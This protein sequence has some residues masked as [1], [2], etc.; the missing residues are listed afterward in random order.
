MK[1]HKLTLILFTICFLQI[2]FCQA[3]DI[4]RTYHWYFGVKAGIDFSNGYAQPDTTGKIAVFAGCSALSDTNGNL[5]MY[6]DGFFVYNRNHQIMPNGDSIAGYGTQ[7]TN[8]NDTT[9]FSYST[10]LGQMPELRRV[11]Q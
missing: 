10:A 9:T 8:L 7:Y 3:Q 4:K 1:N 6:T 5:L 2:A 11:I